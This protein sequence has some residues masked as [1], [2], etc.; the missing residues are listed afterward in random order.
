MSRKA[1]AR[2]GRWLL[3]MSTAAAMVVAL[4]HCNGG[5]AAAPTREVPVSPPLVAEA[6]APIDAGGGEDASDGGCIDPPLVPPIDASIVIDTDAGDADGGE[7][8]APATFTEVYAKVLPVCL[9]CHGGSGN[10]YF[11]TKCVAYRNLV[12]VP[13]SGPKCGS[14]GGLVRVIPGDADDSLIINKLTQRPTPK[15]GGKMP[16]AGADLTA[17]KIDLLRR[18]INAGAKY[19]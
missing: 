18:W 11:T 7:A 6:S 16:L 4:A 10:Q 2:G 19:D 13:A 1:R 5:D 12:N 3:A 17:D 15:C 14:V 8:G 9:G